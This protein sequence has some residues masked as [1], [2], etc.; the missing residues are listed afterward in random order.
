M[1]VI[2]KRNIPPK[3]PKILEDTERKWLQAEV[4]IQDGWWDEARQKIE[5]RRRLQLGG[6]GG[7][8]S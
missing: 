1:L 8:F 6:W 4:R 3:K 2:F 7:G 5:K